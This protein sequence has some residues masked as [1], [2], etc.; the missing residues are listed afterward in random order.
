MSL[1]HIHLQT[2][3]RDDVHDDGG[4]DSVHHD[5]ALHHGQVHHRGHVRDDVLHGD[6][7]PRA[8][9]H[10]HGHGLNH[11]DGGDQDY[12]HHPRHQA[13][14]LLKGPDTSLHF[15]ILHQ[16]RRSEC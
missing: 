13:L 7:V 5:S 6:G 4:G 12:S 9:P 1:F 8:H 10:L 16:S 3:L 11:G 14:L 2:H 15:H